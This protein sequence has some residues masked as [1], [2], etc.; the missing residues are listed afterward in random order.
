MIIPGRSKRWAPWPTS[1]KAPD[2]MK[3]ALTLLEQVRDKTVPKLGPYHPLTLE[4]LN[5]LGHMYRAYGRMPEAI[6][7]LE[8]VREREL[9]FSGPPPAHARHAMGAGFGVLELR[10]HE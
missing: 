2:K 5:R 6:A 8:L 10:G 7:L 1:I 3:Q 4:T 9:W